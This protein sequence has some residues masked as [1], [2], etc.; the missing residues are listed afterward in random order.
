MRLMTF[1]HAMANTNSATTAS[2]RTTRASGG[3]VPFDVNVSGRRDS[4]ADDKTCSGPSMLHEIRS[5][6][7]APPVPTYSLERDARRA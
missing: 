5:S 3:S 4:S 6:R 7:A 2:Q 1:E